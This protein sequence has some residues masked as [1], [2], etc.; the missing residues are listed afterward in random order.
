MNRIKQFVYLVILVI[1]A[2]IVARPY[3]A[4]EFP[5]THDGENHLARFANYK[6]AI[7][8]GQL[9]PRFAPNLNARYGYPVFNYNYPLANILS[10]P[11]SVL[12]FSY[13]TTLS[14]LIILSIITAG[15]SS[16]FLSKIVGQRFSLDVSNRNAAISAIIYTTSTHLANLTFFRGNIGETLSYALIPLILLA[17]LSQQP[18]N[19]WFRIVLLAV[20]WSALL[21]SH[22]ITAVLSI[23]VLVV[24]IVFFDTALK[25]NL[26][27]H[28]PSFFLGIMAS[29][30][31]WLPALHEISE[32]IVSTSHNNNQASFHLV[33]LTQLLFGSLQF[34]FSYP[35]PID[36][37]S[38][39][40]SLPQLIL[41]FVTGVLCSKLFVSKTFTIRQILLFLSFSVGVA[42]LSILQSTLSRPIWNIP[43]LS[44]IQF[45]WRLQAFTSFL[46]LIISPILLVSLKAWLQR[47]LILLLTVHLVVLLSLNP[48]DSFT[49]PNE[50]YDSFGL[51]TST[52]NENMPKTYR[53]IPLDPWEPTA[54]VA[55][56]SAK[57]TSV[58]Y[59]SGSRRVYQVENTTDSLLIEPTAYFLGWETSA[60]KQ[61]V[62]YVFTDET[63]GRIAYWL[64]P[65]NYTIESAFTQ[66]TPARKV[67]NAVSSFA[68]ALILFFGLLAIVDG[69][70]VHNK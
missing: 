5:Y 29:F 64:P 15:I 22:T 52:E 45:P 14:L 24:C 67:G 27:L 3:L 58:K 37:L 33:E 31:Y 19:K 26:S 43:A 41:L 42:L 35:G 70:K 69:R 8:E 34:G 9:P 59:W 7:R 40:Y 57:V 10:V 53:F 6:I 12:N 47:V 18:K 62:A 28:I 32:V 56:G 13:E 25:K 21:L 65:G 1:I 16:F 36:S 68:V 66:D 39:A 51:T 4:R 48:A 30:W 46:L 38:F 23:P 55:S 61:P 20:L 49:H 2:L 17:S 63:Q 50:Y 11:F 44:F 60:N 54:L